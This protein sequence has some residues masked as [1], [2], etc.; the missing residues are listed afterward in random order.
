MFSK[1]RRRFLRTSTLAAGGTA[2]LGLI[3][4]S[5]R[6]AMAIPANNATGSIMDVGHVVIHMQENR[7][8]DHYLGALNGVRGF[9]DPRAIRLPGGNSVWRQP[10][11]E[12]ADGYV[13]PFHGDSSIT[14]SFTVDGSGQSHQD[15]LTILN[16]GRYDQWGHTREL[17]KRMVYY[18]AHDLPFYYALASAFTVCDHFFCS[19]LTQ[20]YPNRLHLFSGC[21]GG[22]KVGGDP[23]MTNDGTDETPTADMVDDKPFD[24]YTWITYAEQLQAGGI[25]W[26]VFQEYDNF[27]DN[28]LALFKNFRNINDRNSPLYRNGR[29]WVSEYDPNLINRKRSDGK[30][31][32]QAFRNDLA[33]G[34]LPQ[35]SWIVT[36]AKL[37]EHPDYVPPNGENITAQLVEALV[38]HPNMF[39]KTVLIINYDEVGGMFDHVPP[40]MPPMHPRDGY[41]TVSTEGEAKIYASRADNTGRQPIGLGMRVPAIIVSPWSRGGWVCSEVFDHTSTLRFMEA[42]FGVKSPN[43]SDWRRAVCG[44]LTSSFDFKNPNRNWAD[45]TLPDTANYLARIE[46]SLSGANLE[47]PAVQEPARQDLQ[48]RHARPLPYCLQANARETKDGQFV[49]E[50]ENL[51]TT[52]AVFQI[53]DYT[54]AH[55]PWRYTIEPGEQYAAS[56]WPRI[57]KSGG[58]HLAVHG[59]N[60]FYRNFRSNSGARS[61]LARV[62]LT[63]DRSHGAIVLTLSNDGD[64]SRT[65]SVTQSKAYSLD[66]GQ[67]R[68]RNYEVAPA[69]SVRSIWTLAASDHWYDIS[70]RIVADNEFLYQYAGHVET[71]NAS[72]TDPA[73]GAMHL[74]PA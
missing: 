15:N 5:I 71:D 11:S 24:A 74:L 2:A 1:E 27:Q 37:S 30:Q 54:D 52:G 51:G 73:I 57:S 70:I 39:A 4:A 41:S 72:K 56:P 65:F 26:K 22:G 47:I 16:S 12:H 42:R 48:Q 21:N 40:P 31:L 44:D 63:E 19:T 55:G 60:G 67:S 34:T 59:P 36:A 3:P 66:P 9:G 64:A 20:T 46:R 6:K 53:Y 28:L 23:N 43:I 35:V 38:D 62:G 8:F 68:T 18:T 69:S 17:H 49:V 14:R 61:H 45:L 7:S 50:L 13:M 10:S 58:Y 32:V 33:A 25:S 29:S